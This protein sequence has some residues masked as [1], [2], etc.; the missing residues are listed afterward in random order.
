MLKT[1]EKLSLIGN[2]L[3]LLSKY[4]DFDIFREKFEVE[5][6]EKDRNNNAGAKLLMLS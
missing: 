2:P 5:L 3:K 1:V 6:L 4:I